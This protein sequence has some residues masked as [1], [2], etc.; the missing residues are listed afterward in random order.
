MTAPALL[1][2]RKLVEEMLA[3]CAAA[4]AVAARHALSDM[5]PISAQ[6]AAIVAETIT[7]CYLLLI[8]KGKAVVRMPQC[9]EVPMVLI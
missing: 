1:A 8:R 7:A 2:V 3:L 5:E 9:N 6:L 4:G